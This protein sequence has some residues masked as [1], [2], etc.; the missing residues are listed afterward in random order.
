MPGFRFSWRT[1]RVS[2]YDRPCSCVITL[3]ELHCNRA[4]LYTTRAWFSTEDRA[5]AVWL[6]LE[7]TGRHLSRR[8]ACSRGSQEPARS[9]R[10]C[11]PC[12]PSVDHQSRERHGLRCRLSISGLPC[13]ACAGSKCYLLKREA[14]FAR[15]GSGQGQSVLFQDFCKAERYRRRGERRR[16]EGRREKE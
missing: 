8:P 10:R 7:V 9:C 4:R 6:G 12:T 16:E 3:P 2:S 14:W 11:Y 5:H 1:A 15:Y 13:C